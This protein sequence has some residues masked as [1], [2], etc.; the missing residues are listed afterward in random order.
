[1]LVH[2]SL[3]DPESPA[4]AMDTL[5]G[6]EGVEDA[7]ANTVRHAGTIV[8]DGEHDTSFVRCPPCDFPRSETKCAIVPHNVERLADQIAEYDD[9]I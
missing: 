8:G 7:A 1:M 6:V 3:G 5:G 4:R 9:E 2:N